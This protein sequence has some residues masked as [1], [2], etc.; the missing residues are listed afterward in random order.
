MCVNWFFLILHPKV[1]L[2]IWHFD[3]RF[4]SYFKISDYDVAVDVLVNN[5]GI[6][7]NKDHLDEEAARKTIDT[8]YYGVLN[9]TK[10]F[11]P[12]MRK[13]GARIVNIS[14]TLGCKALGELSQSLQDSFL[15]PNLAINQYVSIPD[16][17]NFPS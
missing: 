5:A 6:S 2:V 7:W 17:R 8:N 10:S 4:L 15:D 9:V 16:M 3:N 14:S 12:I 11:L 1:V 13:P